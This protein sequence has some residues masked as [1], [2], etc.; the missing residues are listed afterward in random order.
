METFIKNLARGAGKILRDGFHRK[1]KIRQKTGFWNLVTNYDLASE[2]FIKD[3][4][5]ARFPEDAIL[6]EESG[7]KN[8][9]AQKE[10]LWIVD[11]LDGTL[12]FAKGIA[13]FSVSI[14][15]VNYETIQFGAIYDPIHDELFFARRGKGAFLN[16][17]R[18]V[19]A[20]LK[21][22]T[23]VE[24]AVDVTSAPSGRKKVYDLVLKYNL[25]PDCLRS[26]AL[27]AAYVSNG[28]LDGII[29]NG[30]YPWDIQRQL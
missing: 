3:K 15:F 24:I 25:M 18:I 30:A 22:L 16:R 10:R 17:H 4:I 20:K 12:A 8:K 26:T 27:T 21:D 13:Q 1:K 7:L 29:S 9:N 2:K 23:H 19:V 6:A 28:R 14:A 5:S 11:P